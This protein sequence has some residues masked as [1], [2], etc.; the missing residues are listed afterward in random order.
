VYK[1]YGGLLLVRPIYT[2]LQSV[3]H[4]LE[5]IFHCAKD[6]FVKALFRLMKMIT[7]LHTTNR[8]R[9]KQLMHTW[10]STFRG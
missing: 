10:S 3:V 4:K 1:V 5:L 9:E 2:K 6:T 8:R 7:G